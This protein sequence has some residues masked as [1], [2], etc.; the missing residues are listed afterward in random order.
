MELR[1]N[2]Y[3]VTVLKVMIFL[4]INAIV[5]TVGFDYNKRGEASTLY[6]IVKACHSM[7][8]SQTE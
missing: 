6:G 8:V 4:S 1:K 3:Q 2:M 5:M 7:V